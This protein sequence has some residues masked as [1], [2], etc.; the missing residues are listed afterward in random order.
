MIWIFGDSFATNKDVSSWSG[1]IGDVNNC[2]SNGSSEYR[3]LKTYRQFE[4]QIS[5]TDKVIFV[6]TSP[7][8]IYLKDDRHSQSRSLKTHK[9]CD[10]IIND[11][12]EKKEKEYIDILESIWDDEYFN[13]M[14]MLIVSE[15][16]LVPNSLHIT[17]FDNTSDGILNLNHLWKRHP[18]TIN[19]L[20]TEGNLEVSKIIC[21]NI[22]TS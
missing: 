16:K 20:S 13:D 15:L 5:K 14:F 12:F 6:H 19:H 18:G 7:S 9:K 22:Y 2:A 10:I 17:F 8:R 21:S 4:N 1:M 11:I 3:I